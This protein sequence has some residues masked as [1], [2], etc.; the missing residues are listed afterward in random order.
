M[1][2]E[3]VMFR[4]GPVRCAGDLYLPD[5]TDGGAP[6]AG[7]VMGH[8]V[9]MVK[10]A[11]RPHAEY[12]VRAG[13]VVLAI[14]WRSV[15]SS[16]GEPRCQ[17]FPQRQV[18]DL[19]AGVSYLRTRREVD[20]ERIGA[21]GH[22]TAAGVAIVAGALDRRIGC[23]AGQNPSMLDGWV[24]L[25]TSRGRA[26]LA[27]MRALVLQDFEQRCQGGEGGSIP[28]LPTDDSKLAGYVGQAEELLPTFKNQMTVES[29]DHVLTWA[30][31]H[32]IHRLAPTPLLLVT[33]VD[34]EVHAIGEVLRAYDLAWQPKRLE[35]LP[36]DEFG[37]SIEPG[38]G[39]SME[40]AAGFFDQ[41]LRQA[42]RFVASPDSEQ[43]WA[44]GLRPE[45]QQT[46]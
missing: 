20:P 46:P 45:Y 14:D 35:L 24:A 21:W 8:S 26:Q 13:F 18:E 36:V 40:L 17:W 10:E 2:V 43:A 15:G 11:L 44:R 28:A 7:V 16:E 34:D 27:A 12:L 23:V 4:S 29:L 5:G 33:G 6:A 39:Q 41:H 31:V 19:R 9:I 32:L 3:H 38:L 1:R 37:L 42:S 25:E 30:P 22:S